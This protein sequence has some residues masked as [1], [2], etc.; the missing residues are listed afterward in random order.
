MDTLLN[1]VVV[2]DHHVLR[3]VTVEA[4]RGQGHYVVGL[5]CAEELP[6]IYD[7]A[8][9]LMV[10][11]LNL[12]GEDGISLVRRIRHGQPN[13][14]IIMLTARTLTSDKLTGYQSGADIY[15]TKP[16]SLEELSSAIQAVARRIKPRHVEVIELQFEMSLLLLTG[17]Q[18]SIS[19]TKQE[20][21]LLVA[22]TRAVEQKLEHWQ[23]IQL[24]D[25]AEKEYSK[26][27]L[28]VIITRLRK[29][30]LTVGSS[31]QRPI[32]SI[33]EYGYQLCEP[34]KLL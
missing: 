15:L 27:N 21:A 34:V 23:L 24:L 4:L 26:A 5:E 32:Q 9:D 6:E 28:E 13:V 12:P 33:R 3:E 1:I 10:I 2:E 19:L 31:S 25:T 17:S 7:M 8:I 16:T 30:L 18:Q 22:F 20:S 29:K 14:G 11:D